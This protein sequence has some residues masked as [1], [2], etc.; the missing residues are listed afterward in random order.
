MIN[1]NYSTQYFSYIKK[2]KYS[3]TYCL[4]TVEIRFFSF[5]T[6]DIFYTLLGRHGCNGN[7]NHLFFEREKLNDARNKH[8]RL[9]VL[10]YEFARINKEAFE[11]SKPDGTVVSVEA[12]NG[13]WS[14]QLTDEYINKLKNDFYLACKKRNIKDMTAVVKVLPRLLGFTLVRENNTD[15]LAYLNKTIKQMRVSDPKY[16]VKQLDDLFKIPK[17][18]GYYRPQK[19]SSVVKTTL[20]EVINRKPIVKSPKP[21]PTWQ[22]ETEEEIEVEL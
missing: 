17:K 20:D 7:I 2:E 21:V 18:L 10:H 14:L 22:I 13:V 4:P 16:P 9:N 12:K 15:L 5:G 6:D 1:E 11:F 8:Q 3:F 19:G